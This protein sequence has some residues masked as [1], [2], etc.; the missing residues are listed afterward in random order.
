METDVTDNR[1]RE[2][3]FTS[4]QNTEFGEYHAE[5]L[6]AAL[7][8]AGVTLPPEPE[9]PMPE[10][11]IDAFSNTPRTTSD[12]RENFRIGLRAAYPHIVA[13]VIDEYWP[14]WANTPDEG[15]HLTHRALHRALKSAKATP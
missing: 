2:I 9:I 1:L 13:A 15:F 10:E 12:W 7:K 8:R 11:A 14:K 6:V 5:R 3:V 4:L